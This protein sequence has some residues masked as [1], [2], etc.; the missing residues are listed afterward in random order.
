MATSRS[1]S[2]SAARE[3]LKQCALLGAGMSLH[4]CYMVSDELHAGKLEV[5]LPGFIPQELDVNVVVRHLLEFLKEWA[6]HPPDWA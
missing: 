4:P 3:A 2:A 6:R 5:L 1:R